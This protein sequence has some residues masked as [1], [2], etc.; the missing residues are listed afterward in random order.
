MLLT[1]L[2]IVLIVLMI[3]G[4]PAWPYARNWGYG[5]YPSGIILIVVIILLVLLLSGRHFGI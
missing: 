1:I 2:I 4:Y 3:G 5:Y